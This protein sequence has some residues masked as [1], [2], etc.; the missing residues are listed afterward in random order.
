MADKL[1]LVDCPVKQKELRPLFSFLRM[2]Q[3]AHS[4][5]NGKDRQ[6]LATKDA[7]KSVPLREAKVAMSPE[8]ALSHCSDSSFHGPENNP[9]SSP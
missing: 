9:R 3:L 5:F 4:P 6:A 1:A 2:Q 7:Q 8:V